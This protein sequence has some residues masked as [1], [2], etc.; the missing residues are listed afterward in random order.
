M[1][2]QEIVQ[3][4]PVTVCRTVYEERVESVPVQVRGCAPVPAPSE[5][6][7]PMP[8]PSPSPLPPTSRPEIDPS[9]PVPAPVLPEESLRPEGKTSS[10]AP[11][12]LVPVTFASYP[13]QS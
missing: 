9:L 1:V 2:E 8:A 11:R 12:P 5:G 13:R 10:E 3:R 6:G 7:C 4:T